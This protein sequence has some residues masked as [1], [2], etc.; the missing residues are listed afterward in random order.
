[1]CSVSGVALTGLE[2]IQIMHDAVGHMQSAA[3]SLPLSQRNLL[4]KDVSMTFELQEYRLP[5]PAISQ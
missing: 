5:S 1:M 4:H 2:L 3:V